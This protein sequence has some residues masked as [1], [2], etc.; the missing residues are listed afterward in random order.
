MLGSKIPGDLGPLAT[1]PV[2]SA[3]AKS[4]A[5]VVRAWGSERSGRLH[6]VADLE[7][8]ERLRAMGIFLRDQVAADARILSP[9]PGAIGY[10]SRRQVVDL[11]GRVGEDEGAHS[12]RGPARADVV[13]ALA[14][15]PEYVVPLIEDRL[16][17]PTQD[18][19]I[20]L[21]LSRHDVVGATPE[22]RV[23]LAEA[24]APYELV[25]VPIPEHEHELTLPSASPGFLLRLRELGLS[26]RLSL[27]PD[28][29][30]LAVL[31]Q[32]DGHHQVVELE[33]T[34]ELPDGEL[35]YVRPDGHGGADRV[36]ARTETLL[37]PTGTRRVKLLNLSLPEDGPVRVGARLLNPMSSP[38]D[39]LAPT[40]APVEL[41]R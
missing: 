15:R 13:A 20:E 25:T 12:W 30:G 32:H 38:D 36:R 2:L 40:C 24:L 16:R 10:L 1:D 26:P 21:L 29:N 27:V 3:M 39:P 31:V 11:L 28:G 5:P 14:A 23:A 9:W 8:S 34:L 35:L 7:R 37:F 22:R 41:L 6:L 18:Q 19:L 33:V 17:P 4:R